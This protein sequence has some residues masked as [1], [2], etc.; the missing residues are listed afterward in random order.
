MAGAYTAMAASYAVMATGHGLS[1]K[2]VATY[3][4][5]AVSAV[6]VVV[7]ACIAAVAFGGFAKTVAVTDQI[8][9]DGRLGWANLGL[10]L[11]A[12]LFMVTG[13][14]ESLVDR[15][16]SGG[17]T[18]GMEI[19]AAGQ[20]VGALAAITAAWAFLISRQHQRKQVDWVPQRDST[21]GL[22]TSVFAVAFLL[23]MVGA[24]VEASA[25]SASHFDVKGVA[26]LWLYSATNLAFTV[27]A[28]SASIGFFRSAR[29]RYY[30]QRPLAE[31]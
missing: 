2:G 5:G 24:I 13:I 10:A 29:R 17:Y 14:L 28:A 16:I 18:D 31:L 20:G 1:A 4:V 22:A 12:F 19:A 9:R 8:A 27:A 7:A 3:A 6:M 15:V 23:M 11:G 26:A 30:S 25:A 21:L